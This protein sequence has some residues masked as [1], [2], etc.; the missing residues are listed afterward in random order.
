MLKKRLPTG[1]VTVTESAVPPPSLR[2]K[3]FV[4]VTVLLERSILLKS[5]LLVDTSSLLTV[6]CAL[7][8]NKIAANTTNDVIAARR[9]PLENTNRNPRP[10]L[11]TNPP[12]PVMRF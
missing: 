7:A 9:A 1:C 11:V 2:V 4:S 6:A 10:T 3:D 12:Q 5:R 8:A